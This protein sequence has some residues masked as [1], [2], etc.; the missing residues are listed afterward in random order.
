MVRK[1]VANTVNHQF[2]CLYAA[3]K[4]FKLS[5]I[6]FSRCQCTFY[7]DADLLIRFF[8]LSLMISIQ[9]G[10]HIIGLLK[11]LFFSDVAKVT[12]RTFS[13]LRD[14]SHGVSE[15]V[16]RLMQVYGLQ[17]IISFNSKHTS[18]GHRAWV[19]MKSC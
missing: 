6:I 4:C 11:V 10:L 1:H 12:V 3:D 9:L 2:R 7:L 8:S 13:K 5:L 17:S 14:K 15:A 19:G 18:R 16:C